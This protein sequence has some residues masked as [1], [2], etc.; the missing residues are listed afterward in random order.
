MKHQYS[1]EETIAFENYKVIRRLR[2][3]GFPISEETCQRVYARWV[4]LLPSG[5]DKPVEPTKEP[6]K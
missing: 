6:A 4:Q 5:Q 2:D 1:P 3:E